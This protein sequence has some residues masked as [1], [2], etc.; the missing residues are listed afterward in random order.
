M[1]RRSHGRLAAVCA[2]AA[3]AVVSSVLGQEARV[4]PNARTGGN[5]MHNYYLP[6]APTSTPWA[7][8]WSPDGRSIAVSMNGSIWKVDPASG[9]A[10]ELTY[11]AKY[12]SLPSWS[13]D[14][15]WIIYTAD[16][17][18]QTMQLAIVN[19]ATG[20]SRALTNDAF[21]YTDP[22]FSPDGSRVA[23]VSTRPNGFFNVFIR[24][25]K[26]GQWAGDETAVSTDAKYR[27][28]RLYFGVEDV[29]ITPAW[30]RDGRQLLLVSNR[31]VPLGS[32]NIWLVPAAAGGMND[33]QSVV[34]E[35]TLYRARPDVSIDGKRFVYSSTRGAADQFSNLYV[36]PVTGGEPYK[37]TFFEH[38]AFH[39]RWSPDG[40]W[41]AYIDNREGL[42]Q[43]ALLEVYGGANR[44][45]RIV[46]RRWK[47]PMGMLSVRTSDE[48]GQTT[49]ARIHLTAADGKFYPPADAYAR[50]SLAG[51]RLFHSTGEF[52]VELP[53]G[54]VR[55]TAVKGFE[56]VP[57]EAEFTI[58]P[59]EV[60][61]AQVT[62][63]RMTDMSA[64][65][66]H[67][68]STHVHMNYGGNLHNT[69][70]NLMMMS[71][72]ED[73]DIVLEQIA[74]KDNRILDHQFFV[75]GGGPH[76]LSRKDMV[77]VVGQE[78]RPPFWGHVF[79]FGMREH[80]I[81]PFTTGY[82]GT[83]IESLYPSNTDMF[84][85]ARAQ[86]AYVGY[87]H[88]YAGER[89][90]LEAELGG[91]KGAIV[92]AALG[93]TD[94]IEWSAA[95]RSGFFPL[96][97]L[98]NNGLKVTAVGG[99]DSISNLHMSKLVGSQRTYVFTGD[100]GLDMHA[101]LAGM[102]AGHA[103]VTNGPLV[104]LTVNGALP[105]ETVA[106]QA[107]G[108]TVNVQAHV[109]SIVPLQNA[110]LYFNGRA[111][112][113]IQL[114]ADRRSADFNKTLQVT[115]SGWYHLRAEGAPADRF[116]LDTAYPQ[117]FTNPVWV[118]VG[119]QPIRSRAS[120]EY[121]LSWIDKLQKL[122]EAWPGW[123][124]QKE[125]DHVYGQFDEARRVYRRLAA[126]AGNERRP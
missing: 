26:D 21:I 1:Q 33:A 15:K 28:S 62:L 105:G 91:G 96:Y 110:T 36:Q 5:Y 113:E 78:Y 77:L 70:E 34:V 101:W 83:A 16:D 23:Y 90:P 52:R 30:S 22:V 102:R 61:T 93:T 12:H 89:D 67:G 56:V 108:G 66:W 10:Q 75:P 71:A 63:K 85:K 32:G 87:V 51:D 47:R 106:L 8:A 25:V 80:L 86:G 18:G 122:A 76:P 42:P 58:A 68:G 94:A 98:W 39:P 107:P 13:P 60:T 79:M 53:V 40:E 55:L 57:Q 88:A 65:G 84:R 59:D 64:K 45:V 121:A 125:K 6:P 69:L 14:G 44:L 111:V 82:E 41:I 29:H 11:D 72:A 103:F 24:P 97:A 7:P 73:Q 74:N 50:V 17:G 112:E 118:T 124:S 2:I 37:L 116:P 3:F 99:E 119:N 81:S 27:N 104:E 46:D 54:K 31:G 38:D 100:R 117:G 49:G 109:R 120:A 126:E 35:Q 19:V 9:V 95:G 43:L 92:D 20:E 123:R 48:K 4:Y 115:S 114:S